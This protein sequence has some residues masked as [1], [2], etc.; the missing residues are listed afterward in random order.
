MINFSHSLRETQPP[1]TIRTAAVTANVNAPS[2]SNLREDMEHRTLKQRS[3]Q[4]T[5]NSQHGNSSKNHFHDLLQS[6][7]GLSC[8][9]RNDDSKS[10]PHRVLR[11]NKTELP[12]PARILPYSG[13]KPQVQ[14]GIIL[15]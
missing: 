11:N 9:A 13:I 1:Y 2:L 12:P 15:F 3:T 6:I 8:S 7:E 14:I 5:A 4:Q 10:D